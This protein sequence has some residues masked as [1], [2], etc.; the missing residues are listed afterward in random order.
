MKEAKG[1]K[2]LDVKPL[3]W[4]PMAVQNFKKSIF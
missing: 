1:K 2:K 3:F 4:E